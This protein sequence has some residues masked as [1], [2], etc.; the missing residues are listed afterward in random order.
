[1]TSVR[2]AGPRSLLSAAGFGAIPVI[3]ARFGAGY[4][5]FHYA[6]LAPLF[7]KPAGAWVYQ[8]EGDIFRRG[9]ILDRH[10]GQGPLHENGPDRRCRLPSRT[11]RS[12]RPFLVI[13]HPYPG[14]QLGHETDEPGILHVV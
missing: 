7:G 14:N 12:Q 8:G 13:S 3:R 10:P 6:P 5:A 4:E 11:A 2:P 9:E 1:M